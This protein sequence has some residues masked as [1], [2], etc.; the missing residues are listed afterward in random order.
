MSLNVIAVQSNLYEIVLRIGVAP[1]TSLKGSTTR[2]FM[3]NLIMVDNYI[4]N[5]K[6]LFSLQDQ[7]IRCVADVTNS[8]LAQSIMPKTMV[9]V[10]QTG[11][12]GSPGNIVI[13]K[14]KPRPNIA[15]TVN[16]SQ[17]GM[18]QRKIGG[19]GT[20]FSNVAPPSQMTT[21]M[22]SYQQTQ[23]QM[24]SQLH[25]YYYNN[26]QYSSA[27][28]A[29]PKMQQSTTNQAQQPMNPALHS[30]LQQQQYLIMQ[31]KKRQQQQQRPP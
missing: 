16:D 28:Q 6:F 7:S 26:S 18:K 1:D 21:Q 31:M 25:K 2:F 12:S 22:A 3:K 8:T 9:K 23:Q 17:A 5:L 19:E 10:L 15:M 30:A 13:S 24:Q 20:L 4:Q 14:Q 27:S 11:A 29:S